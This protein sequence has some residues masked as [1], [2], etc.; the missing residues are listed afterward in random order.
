MPVPSGVTAPAASKMP[1]SRDR[2]ES[3]ETWQKKIQDFIRRGMGIRGP[4]ET[5]LSPPY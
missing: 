5:E 2:E 4:V 1:L 3:G